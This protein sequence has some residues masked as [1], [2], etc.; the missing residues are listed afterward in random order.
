MKKTLLAASAAA[1][2]LAIGAPAYAQSKGDMTLGLGIGWVNPPGADG[3]GGALDGK[4]D[5]RPTLTFEYFIADN[6]GL[7]ILAATPFEHELVV[8]GS[9]IGTT[10]HLPPTISVNYHFPTG[11]KVTPFVGAGVNFTHFWDEPTGISIDDSWGFALHAGA[12]FAISD[13]AAIRA[14]IRYIQIE[15]D[16]FSGGTKIGTA[17]INPVVLGVSYI[18]KF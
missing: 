10:K 5:V 12:D 3:I 18:M 6:I 15:S 4:E 16:V 7:E 14:D 11:G 8:G 13:S 9:S 17:E 1:M 2:A